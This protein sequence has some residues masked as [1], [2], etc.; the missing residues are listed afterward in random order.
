MT[1]QDNQTEVTGPLK[2]LRV[3]D[4]T[5]NVLGP[6]ATQI[7]GDMGAD[8]IKV[9][10]PEGDQNRYNGPGR[11][12]GMAVFYLIMNRNKRSIKLDLKRAEC[13]EALMKLVETADVIIHSMRPATA[14]RLGFGYEA[15]AAR[16]PKIIYAHAP[17]YR[18]DG[19]MW[20]SPA[21][22]DV[23]QGESG[24]AA[25]NADADGTP[26][27]FPTVIVDKFCGYVLAS[28]VSMALVHRERTGEGQLIQ[29]PMLET[30]LQFNL[31]EH[32]WEGAIAAN[33]GKGM[34]YTRMFSPHRRPYPTK[35]GY[36]CV[37]AVND[38]QWKKL[39][40][41]IG[42]PEVL[43]DPKFS[44]MSARMANVNLLYAMLADTIVERTTAEW[45][46]V[47]KAND[48]PH[49]PVRQLD[50]LMSDEYLKETGYFQKHDHPTEGEFIMTSIPQFFS[51]SPGSIR[52]LPPVLGEHG[53][54]ILREAGFTDEEI[55]RVLA[56]KSAS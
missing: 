23:I 5:I 51:R 53:E 12:P 13:L 19:P 27:Y 24:I 41:A 31:F 26:R 3:I 11:N 40:K 47:F 25:L 38:Q 15:V 28:T 32:L 45:E 49:G 8:V 20:N 14:E 16:N 1:A 56:E 7:L 33:N 2:G 54:E 37:L 36:I 9:E 44:T 43:E 22:D 34:G 21:F 55:T 35:D 52:R 46:E 50:D 48:I 6:V 39:M 4:L 30:M 10:P 29:V 18:G 42:H 17:G